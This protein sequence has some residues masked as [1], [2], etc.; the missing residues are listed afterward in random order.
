MDTRWRQ[1]GSDSWDIVEVSCSCAY[2][3]HRSKRNNKHGFIYPLSHRI[4]PLLLQRIASYASQ[5]GRYSDSDKMSVNSWVLASPQHAL[6]FFACSSPVAFAFIPWETLQDTQVR[7]CH[8]RD[9]LRLTLLISEPSSG[10]RIEHLSTSEATIP[11]LPPTT[12]T[13]RSEYRG[14]SA[15]AQGICIGIFRCFGE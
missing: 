12:P 1:A 9:L 10:P 7:L 13:I 8:P 11:E 4:Y 14:H 2:L 15:P 3:L 6:I 5:E